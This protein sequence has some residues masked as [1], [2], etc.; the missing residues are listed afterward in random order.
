MVRSYK[1]NI[2]MSEHDITNIYHDEVIPGLTTHIPCAFSTCLVSRK[3]GRSQEEESSGPAVSL[4]WITM[5]TVTNK[6][7][8]RKLS[9]S[10]S[11]CRPFNA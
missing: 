3:A 11:G 1:L 9:L 7:T 5:K 8:K 2:K 6:P 10:L 4:R